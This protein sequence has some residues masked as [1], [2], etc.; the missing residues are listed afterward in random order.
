MQRLVL[1]STCVVVSMVLAA[2][3]GTA[4]VECVRYENTPFH[5]ELK[6]SPLGGAAESI[7]CNLGQYTVWVPVGG[8]DPSQIGV[9]SGNEIVFTRNASQASMDVG[10]TRVFLS[11]LDSE[12]EAERLW[13]LVQFPEGPTKRITAIDHGLDGQVDWRVIDWTN[14]APP[15]HEVLIEG[16]WYETRK[17]GEGNR[18]ALVNG[19]A[20]NFAERDHVFV[21][22]DVARP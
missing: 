13:Y 20:R 5:P 17:D 22:S 16:T 15:T 21:F 14:D 9:L 4:Q 12:G 7:Q 6:E 11:N 10:R 1:L 3:R 8:D 18:I 19:V 2:C